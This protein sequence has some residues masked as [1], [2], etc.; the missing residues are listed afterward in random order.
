MEFN[1]HQVHTEWTELNPEQ[2][3]CPEKKEDTFLSRHKDCV[4]LESMNYFCTSSFQKKKKLFKSTARVLLLSGLPQERKQG[5]KGGK[6]VKLQGVIGF[7][8]S[9]LLTAQQCS[10]AWWD[11]DFSLFPGHHLAELQDF[12][13]H[14]SSV[15]ASSCSTTQV[16]Q[17]FFHPP[18]IFHG[19]FKVYCSKLDIS[20]KENTLSGIRSIFSVS[21]QEIL[22]QS[23]QLLVENYFSEHI[24]TL[25]L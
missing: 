3:F 8:C 13:C 4:W 6:T 14:L 17:L 25:F 23:W 12:S 10:R 7:L 9:T 21:V 2:R 20:I 16:L 22:L 19:D 18:W 15:P 11:L 1:S 5:W 24:Q